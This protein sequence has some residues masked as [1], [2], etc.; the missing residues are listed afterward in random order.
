MDSFSL[1]ARVCKLIGAHAKGEAFWEETAEAIAATPG[2][3]GWDKRCNAYNLG[4]IWGDPSRK[5]SPVHR[6][7]NCRQ[8]RLWVSMYQD[9]IVYLEHPGSKHYLLLRDIL[10]EGSPGLAEPSTQEI[11][12]VASPSQN[13][14]GVPGNNLQLRRRALWNQICFTW[15]R[16]R[17]HLMEG[18]PPLTDGARF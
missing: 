2:T 6:P 9:E 5:L 15:K 13:T 4:A 7:T 16:L 8:L 1:D 14:L 11:G 18:E 10:S 3:K 17:F 12:S